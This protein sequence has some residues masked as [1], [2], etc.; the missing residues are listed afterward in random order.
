ML[1]AE[2]NVYEHMGRRFRPGGNSFDLSDAIVWLL[3]IAGVVVLAWFLHKVVTQIVQTKNH[4]LNHLFG[5]LCAAHG[6]GW[7][8]RRLLYRLAGVHRLPHPVHLF[9][10]PDCFQ[11]QTLPPEMSAFQSEV[12]HLRA[13]LFGYREDRAAQSR[14]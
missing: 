14:S 8:G 13:T 10:R 4:S 1:V 5:Q 6:V 2:S 11:P 9:L 12:S 7:Y 3:L